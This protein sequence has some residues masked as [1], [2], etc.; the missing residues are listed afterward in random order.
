MRRVGVPKVFRGVTDV[1]V[2]ALCVAAG[3]G[4]AAGILFAFRELL[5]HLGLPLAVAVTGGIHLVLVAQAKRGVNRTSA[6]VAATP[7]RSSVWFT[8]ITVGLAGLAYLVSYNA[9]A[10]S[11]WVPMLFSI[12][13][14]LILLWAHFGQG[15]THSVLQLILLCAAITAS[16]I[17]LFPYDGDDTWTHIHNV[18]LLTSAAPV[19]EL[20]PGYQDYPAYP[21]LGAV[22]TQFMHTTAST[23]LRTFSTW[24]AVTGLLL[25]LG[26][27]VSR[28][29]QLHRIVLGLVLLGSKW[30]VYW[31]TYGVAMILA[32]A[33]FCLVVLLLFRH[34][35]LNADLKD[36]AL[37]LF[38]AAAVPFFHPVLTVATAMLILGALLIVKSL[39]LWAAS[40]V[41]GVSVALAAF[42]VVVALAQWMYYGQSTFARTGVSFVNAILREGDVG[43]SPLEARRMLGAT[44]LDETNFYLLLVLAG[45][46][47][48]RRSRIGGT[49]LVVLSGATGLGFVAFGYGVQLAHFSPALPDR[50]FIFGSVL[51]AIPA[52][53]TV[54]RAFDSGRR[55]ARTTIAV[56]VAIFVFTSMSNN[57]VSRG[58]ILYGT[59][60]RFTCQMTEA[61]FSGVRAIERV[62]RESTLR[63][64]TDGC[65]RKYLQHVSGGEQIRYWHAENLPVDLSMYKGLFS[66]RPAYYEAPLVGNSYVADFPDEMHREEE[67]IARLYDNGSMQLLG[68][69]LST[70]RQ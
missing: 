16:T 52:S 61:E 13:A 46:E 62:A 24:A 50:W 36:T 57:Q 21:L 58:D 30:Y 11:I 9:L 28:A 34:L 38:V 22:L 64:T 8:L 40:K 54:A 63:I 27:Q 39:R 7:R 1:Q 12:L 65:A 49:T 37:L 6:H 23:S 33:M 55:G 69:E 67:T 15:L 29:S 35:R 56:L 41:R 59:M 25:V 44:L 48:L 68:R 14:V 17:V 20:S 31:S 70:G 66:S 10:R 18:E 4:L 3:I 53:G 19:G 45:L 2:A 60:I 43:A 26:T 42:V 5:P 32:V 47:L 51:L